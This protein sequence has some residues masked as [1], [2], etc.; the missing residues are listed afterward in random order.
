MTTTTAAR[1][2]F[3]HLAATAG[4]WSI[5]AEHPD[6]GPYAITD[7]AGVYVHRRWLTPRGSWVDTYEIAR[8]ALDTLA[9]IGADAP[10]L[11]VIPHVERLCRKMRG[12]SRGAIVDAALL[13]LYHPHRGL[14]AITEEQYARATGRTVVEVRAYMER[15]RDLSAVDAMVRERADME[16]RVAC[17]SLHCRKCMSGTSFA[18]R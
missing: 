12:A 10:S 11:D 16:H 4:F 5:Y 18:L 6:R 8:T 14:R 2:A 7:R 3:A 9:A 15:L 1:P 17:R 13:D